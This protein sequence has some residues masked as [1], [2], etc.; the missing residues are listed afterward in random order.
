MIDIR[1][2]RDLL[3]LFF[4]FQREF[5][6]ALML[7]VLIAVAGAF[8]LPHKYESE[9]R[10]LVKSGRENLT[11]PIDAGDRQTMLVPTSSRDPMIDEEQ[12]LTGRPVLLQ[13]ARLYLN[14]LANQPPPQ[15]W[16]KRTM[17]QVK[18]GLEGLSG[19]IKSITQALGLTEAQSPEERLAARLQDKFQVSH[20]PGSNV[21]ELHFAWDDPLVAQRIMQTWVKVFIDERTAALG[22][23]GLVAFYQG[24]VRDADQQIESARSLW[25]TQLDK[26]QGVSTQ[27]R[28]D[29]LTK[30]LNDLRTRRAEITA[31]REALQHGLSYASGRARGL[32]RDTVSEREMGYGPAW[33]ALN[34][35]LAELKRQRVEALRTFKDTAP[36]IVAINE[37]ITSLE[38]QLKAEAKPVQRSERRSPNELS[39]TIERSDLEKSVRLQELSTY[40]ASYDKEIAD[41]EQS[42]KKVQTNEPELTRLEQALSVAEKNRSLYLDSLEKAQVDQALDESRINNIAQI[43]APTFNPSRT[44]PKSLVLLGLA[45]PA[46]ALVGLLVIYLCS[47]ADQRIHDGGRVE[48]RLGVPL[49]STVKDVSNSGEDNEFQASLYRI[50]GMLPRERLATE[51]LTL[52]LTS[53]RAGEGVSFLAQRLKALLQSQGVTVVTQGLPQPGQVELIEASALLNNREAFVE[54]SHA[55]LIVLVVEACASTV[56][57]VEN[58]LGVLRTAF[59]QVDGII[60][61]RRRFEV[62]PHVLQWLQR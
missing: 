29:A 25:R 12:M 37:S 54:L 44:S 34:T 22:R 17:L 59:N 31:E 20:T 5:K 48:Q 57:V 9:A 30:R 7:T 35:Q 1:S 4:I 28:L 6:I 55:N 53:S 18:A 19:G 21:M 2:L 52:A 43:E 50:Y 46:G 58:A 49:W 42:R 56:P 14:E 15:S 26:I 10:L 41:L 39:A 8:L 36:T 3:R 33:T 61:N 40:A 24:K 51:G 45:L 47:L 27:E 13:V 32:S 23:K 62:P 38:A 16:W 11:V 60:I